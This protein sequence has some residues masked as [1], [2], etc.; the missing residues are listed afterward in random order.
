MT[1]RFIALSSSLVPKP[2]QYH[3]WAGRRVSVF[4]S[5]PPGHK[6]RGLNRF[7]VPGHVG[8]G[9]SPRWAVVMDLS[10]GLRH[11]GFQR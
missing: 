1:R 10:S 5:M 2:S 11:L 4:A 6:G 9:R 7:P 8:G 3:G